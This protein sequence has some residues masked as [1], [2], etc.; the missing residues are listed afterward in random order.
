[1]VDARL[2]RIDAVGERQSAARGQRLDRAGDGEVRV[3]EVARDRLWMPA[4]ERE[5]EL[6]QV[7]GNPALSVGGALDALDVEECG[8]YGPRCG[9]ERDLLG[10][11]VR[12]G[13]SVGKRPARVAVSPHDRQLFDRP[14][15]EQ[16]L[17]S[18]PVVGAL[19]AVYPSRAEASRQ[20]E[21]ATRLDELVHALHSREVDSIFVRRLAIR[22]KADVLDRGNTNDGIERAFMLPIL[23]PCHDRRQIAVF[24]GIRSGINRRYLVSEGGERNSNQALRRADIEHG[25]AHWNRSELAE[26][27][28][29]LDD[30]LVHSAHEDVPVAIANPDRRI[31][32]K[33]PFRSKAV[34]GRLAV[35]DAGNLRFQNGDVAAGNSLEVFATRLSGFILERLDLAL[36]LLESRVAHPLAARRASGRAARSPQ[37]SRAMLAC[38]AAAIPANRG[39]KNR[40]SGHRRKRAT[41]LS[42]CLTRLIRPPPGTAR[43]CAR[44]RTYGP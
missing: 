9:D 23:D 16:L 6:R 17:E 41:R 11:V 27:I 40:R 22:T 44:V 43:S 38:I 32:K 37:P 28:R 15:L 13:R 20:H 8:H 4:L 33:P 2:T 3:E 21:K 24:E 10:A 39:S 25:G 5:C 29:G 18:R 35:Q 1:M 19:E 42:A 31:E 14:A 26:D 12:V 36:L 7:T 30:S 34:G